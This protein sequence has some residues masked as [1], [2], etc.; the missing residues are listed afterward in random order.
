[1]SKAR[2]GAPQSVHTVTRASVEREEALL[3]E[4]RVVAPS[5]RCR[6]T[7]KYGKSS[8]AAGCSA[9]RQLPERTPAVAGAPRRRGA[10]AAASRNRERF[11]APTPQSMQRA[12]E[13]EKGRHFL[14]VISLSF[15]S[16]SAEPPWPGHK[17]VKQG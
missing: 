8:V 7:S 15:S 4:M 10:Q 13:V 2:V 3:T 14:S 5:A 12:R 16:H 11:M 17:P 1:M 6:S 9:V